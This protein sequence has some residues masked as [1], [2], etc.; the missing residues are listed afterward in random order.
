MV[1]FCDED[2][3][4]LLVVPESMKMDH[5]LP[6]KIS[7]GKILLFIKLSDMVLNESNI[8][9]SVIIQ[10]I[11][12]PS[13][14]ES[15]ELISN[16]VF[17]PVLSNPQNQSKWGE[18][19]AREILDKFHNFLSS[20]TII[21][22]QIK[23]ETRLPMPP[24]DLSG[25]PSAT[26]KNK[27][28]L[29]E[30]A[31]ITWTKQIR[32]ILKLD[33]EA[34]LKAG[35]NPTPDVEIEFWKNKAANLNS[36]F[37]QLQGPRIRRV[38]KALD[39]SKSTYST[40]FARLCKEVFSARMEANDNSKYLRTLE[41]WFKDLNSEDDFPKTTELFKPMM[42]IILL[43]WKNSK[44]YNCSP[45]LVV[46]IREICNSVI[47]Q[48]T[49]YVSGELIF[50]M[51]ESEEASQAVSMLKTTLAVC[52][53]FK[54]TYHDYK[55]TA[56]AECP[57]NP[58]KV[59]SNT[60]FTRL[61]SFLERCHD[62]LELTQTIVSF[63][64]LAKI[65]IGGTKGKTLTAS[66]K[67]IHEDFQR[68][69]AA[70]KVVPYDI[71]DVGAKGFDDDFYQ[72][73]CSIKELERRLGAVVALAF[74]DC[75][76][77]Y[78]RFKLFDSFEGLLDRPIIQ[79]ELE[80][81]YVNVVQQYGQDMKTIQ[82]LFL[83]YR[84]S[85]PIARN[86]PPIAGA[87]TWCRGLVE[88]IQIPMAKLNQL[89]RSIIEREEAKEVAKV[90]TTI[91]ALLQDFETQKI[92][93][94][95]RDVEQSSQAKLKLPLLV[96]SPE[97]RHLIVNFDPALVKLLREVKYFLLLGLTVPDSALEIYQQVE[98]FRRWTG[99]L[100]LI[101]NMNNDVLS[102]LL[103]VE[104]PLIQPYLVKFD[105]SVEKGLA[106]MNWKSNGITEFIADAMDQ[107]TVVNDIVKKMKDNLHSINEQLKTYN[108]PLLQRKPKPVAK[109]EFEKDHKNY[110][111]ERYT[112]IKEGGKHIQ[113]MVKDTNKELRVSNASTD[114]RSYVEFVNNVV[115]NGL[116]GIIQTSLGYL[117]DQISPENIAKEDLKPMVEVKLDL[118]SF[119]NEDGT[120]YEEVRFLPDL[121]ESNG[122]GVRDLLNSWIGS[123]LN[124]ATLFKRLD[125]E[126][127]YLREMHTDQGV[128]MYL[129][130]ISEAI[131]ENEER[132]LSV[133]SQYNKHSYLWTTDMNV[134]F[135][136]F[137]ADAKIVTENGQELIDLAKFEAAI[138]KYE[139]IRASIQLVIEHLK[140]L[141][142][143]EIIIHV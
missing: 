95:S 88:R 55:T 116:S 31:I 108:K 24:I 139:N 76:T 120:R 61:D 104:V 48:A 80:S 26:G 16:E 71:M 66:T 8:A 141:N 57:A 111:K 33:P 78:G 34:P 94:W 87:L 15:L 119:K 122:K 46:L 43:I 133:A 21:S 128:C 11:G 105:T 123:F 97:N 3:N 74:D 68:A 125:N 126:G 45:C 32:S 29:L 124:V 70:F 142:I 112:E 30:G 18:V 100:D 67:H 40:T 19:P 37:E 23:G 137:C 20:T 132:C 109:D 49:K 130:I 9:Q 82:E 6:S 69:I 5:V 115:V 136:D 84:D 81:K 96:R 4:R 62:I 25:G 110:V 79:D 77:I 98:V 106:A 102:I 28:S 86:M 35:L 64:K 143:L 101:V 129:A 7:K 56:N 2:V 138:C 50:G 36:I 117:Y 93:E 54:S 91:V 38:L 13:P 59:Q 92:D 131:T 121:L 140:I 107:V 27:I 65:E 1:K 22:G 52:G 72:F 17:L 134:F 12:G 47:A 63:S 103:P 73:R 85:P 83:Q 42:H 118:Q 60:L 10:E 135:A 99:N 113:T 39:Q 89:D 41:E 58:W 127:T 114:W 90:F 14:F 51:I 53:N 75:S 44:H